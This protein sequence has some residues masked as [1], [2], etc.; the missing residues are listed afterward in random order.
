M[1]EEL[2]KPSI[3]KFISDHE[4]DD[5]FQLALKFK[6]VDGVPFQWIAQQIL[7]LQKIKTKIP[8]WYECENIIYPVKLSL[9]QSSSQKTAEYKATLVSGNSFVDLTAG[10]GVDS[11][12]LSKRFQK[13]ITLEQNKELSEITSHNL[14]SLDCNHVEVVNELAE[15]FLNSSTENFDLIYL[16][17]ARRVESKKVFLLEDCEPNIVVLLP[18]LKSRAK[19]ILIKTSPLMDINQSIKELPGVTDV[20]VVSVNNDCKEVLYHITGEEKS[21]EIH[22][23]NFK[24]SGDEKFD[25]TIEQEMN[26]N[27]EFGVVDSYLYEPNSAILKAGAFKSI[28]ANLGLKKL[29]A[30]THLYTNSTLIP[31]FPGRSFK[32]VDILQYSKKELKGKFPHNKANITVRNFPDTV[33]MIRKKLGLKDG[34]EVYLFAITDYQG[35]LQILNCSKVNKS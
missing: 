7:G 35:K 4:K 18:L 1:I 28:A 11:W 32:I 2:L 20:H 26:S 33:E 21:L 34:G 31:D 10:M 14:R 9:E 24:S 16:D 25:F 29:H 3:K 8:G 30:N 27:V 6:E 12:A 13:G 19:E 17:P 23:I 15:D 5:P 22:T